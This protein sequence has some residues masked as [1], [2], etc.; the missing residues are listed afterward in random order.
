L[1]KR[2]AG[3]VRVLSTGTERSITDSTPLHLSNMRKATN[4]LVLARASLGVTSFGMQI[5]SFP[6]DRTDY[7]EHSHVR[8]GPAAP[9]PGR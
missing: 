1:S 5:A 3:L 6:P 9:V 2:L 4:G 8:V 7:P